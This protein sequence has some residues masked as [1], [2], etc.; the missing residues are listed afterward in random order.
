MVISSIRG[1]LGLLHCPSVLQHWGIFYFVGI[2]N[3][4]A[5]TN[6]GNL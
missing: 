4:L 5:F 3:M 6:V 1:S 2:T